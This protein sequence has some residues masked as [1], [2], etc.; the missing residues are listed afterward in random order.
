ML[1]SDYGFRERSKCA[2]YTVD[3]QGEVACDV[4]ELL[5]CSWFNIMAF[6][7]F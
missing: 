6:T 3:V 1:A 4:V 7:R 2:K 5:I